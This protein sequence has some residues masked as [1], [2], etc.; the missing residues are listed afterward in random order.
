MDLANIS[1]PE[2]VQ[3]YSLKEVLTKNTQSQ[4]KSA[5]SELNVYLDGKKSQGY[6]IKTNRY[7]FIR[8]THKDINYYELYDHNYDTEENINLVN[9]PKYNKVT[10]SLKIILNNRITTARKKPNGLGRQFENAKPTFEPIR[11][12]SVKKSISN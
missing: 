8:W 3:G 11:I 1:T 12:K 6:S 4:R 7:R 10:D 5:F 2:F 9:D